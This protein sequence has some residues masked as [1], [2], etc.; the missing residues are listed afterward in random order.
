ML[1]CKG[2]MRAGGFRPAAKWAALLAVVFALGAG[3]AAAQLIA[4]TTFD[5]NGL[6][7][8]VASRVTEGGSTTITV[9]V[10]AS[11]PAET[12]TATGVTVHFS[13]ESHGSLGATNEASDILIPATATL[14]F[15][16]NTTSSAVTHTV[17]GSIPLQTN[18]DLDAEDETIVLA[19]SASGGIT[20][21]AG[22]QPGQEP[23][24]KVTIDD[25]ETQTYVVALATG[26]VPREGAAFGLVVRAVPDHDEVV[27]RLTLQIDGTGYVLNTDAQDRSGTLNNTT[28]SFTATVTPPNNDGNRTDDAVTV[29]AYSGTVGNAT[30]EASYTFTVADTHALP[31]PAAVTVEVKDTAGRPATSV[32]EGGAVT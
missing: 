25:D 24:P 23:R 2:A 7:V 26:A 28:T 9:T 22:D 12:E 16:A 13:P 27:K 1:T 29:K 3:E 8:D 4:D 15:P 21:E 6:K 17:S 18:H 5:G 11:V 14:S 19:I 31:A 10:K 32:A 30:E 20:I